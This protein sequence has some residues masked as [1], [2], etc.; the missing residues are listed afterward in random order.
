MTP[1]YKTSL[2][3]RRLST[4][5]LLI[6]TL[7]KSGLVRHRLWQYGTQIYTA[8]RYHFTVSQILSVDKSAYRYKGKQGF[9]LVELIVTIAVLAI[10]MTIAAPAIRTQ[11]ARMEAKRIK[12]QVENSLT[13][14]K[15]ES[16]IRRKNII[17][18]LSNAGGRCHR[19]SDQTLLLFIDKNDNKNFDAQ[20][21]LLIRQR[22][23]N[24]KYAKLSLHVGGRRHYIKFWG[25]SGKPRGHFGHIKYCPTVAYNNAMYLISF[26]QSGRIRQKLNENHPTK[27]DK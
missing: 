21:D 13:L 27:C 25:D 10:I 26:S 16:Y 14:A 24:P 1:L 5:I 17:V 11:L 18:C 9:T 23:L 3:D 12:N 7:G 8:F 4:S 15:T 19:D 2:S 22:A 20:T 6:L